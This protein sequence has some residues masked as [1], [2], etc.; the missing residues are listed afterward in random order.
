ML[1]DAVDASNNQDRVISFEF[2]DLKNK[3][4]VNL[5]KALVLEQM[6]NL[7]TIESSLAIVKE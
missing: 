5:V 6:L 4:R 1:Q 3:R 2:Y 7:K